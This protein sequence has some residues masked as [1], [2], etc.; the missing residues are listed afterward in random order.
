MLTVMVRLVFDCHEFYH[1]TQNPK[2]VLFEPQRNCVIIRHSEPHSKRPSHI[3]TRINLQTR[4]TEV[5]Y[6]GETFYSI[7]S[8]VSGNIYLDFKGFIQK[9]LPGNKVQKIKRNVHYENL[10]LEHDPPI[11]CSYLID[12]KL[13]TKSNENYID[14]NIPEIFPQLVKIEP[15][16]F[17][18][19]I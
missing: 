14:L 15:L 8:D 17:I 9:L 19:P 6:D 12:T 1:L 16:S 18:A 11:N 4:L 2:I 10:F 13:I 7:M 5:I 3:L